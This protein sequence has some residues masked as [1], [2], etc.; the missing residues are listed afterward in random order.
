MSLSRR[1]GVAI[2]TATAIIGALFYACAP[3]SRAGGAAGAGAPDAAS[4]TYIAPGSYDDFY[5]FMSGG[6]SGQIGV[7]G[8]P[9]GRLLKV[10]PVFSQNAENGYGYNDETKGMLNTSF[11]LVPWDDTHHPSLSQTAGM[12][13]GAGFSRTTTRREFARTIDRV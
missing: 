10:I 4:R 13:A 6:F 5:A 11:G 3:A 8:L 9:S 1:A 12:H 2:G 7:Y